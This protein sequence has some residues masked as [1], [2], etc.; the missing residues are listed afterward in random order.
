[1]TVTQKRRDVDP[2]RYA[3]GREVFKAFGRY[4]YLSGRQVRDLLYDRESDASRKYALD[5]CKRL[6]EAGLLIPAN[7]Y[8]RGVT[9]GS[10]EWVWSRTEKGRNE[11][12]RMDYPNPVSVP[13][14]QKLGTDTISHLKLITDSMIAFERV[15][16]ETPGVRLLKQWHELELRSIDLPKVLDGYVGYYLDAINAPLGI[17]LE[18]D[19]GTERR[20]PDR[21]GATSIDDGIRRL[22]DLASGPHEEA[23]GIQSI[24]F[25]W[26]INA[27][28]KSNPD[29]LRELLH[30]TEE[31]LTSSANE[32]WGANFFFTIA[33]PATMSPYE[34]VAGNHWIRPFQYEAVPLVALP[35]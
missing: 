29:R 20:Y 16:R 31:A 17:G 23:F 13:K 11:L 21:S 22:L 35:P 10:D 24:R 27:S 9:R 32:A 14:R 3:A 7:S 28:R 19:C 2:L 18:A 33:N 4:Y 30:W 34:F 15:G 1:M 5:W 12:D 25:A 6:T 8:D 26:V